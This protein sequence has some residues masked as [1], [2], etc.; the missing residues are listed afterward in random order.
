M[1]QL[2]N[3]A[4]KSSFAMVYCQ[5]FSVLA[6][7]KVKYF[8]HP[9]QLM[10]SQGVSEVKKKKK[11]PSANTGNM[12]LFPMSGRSLGKGNGN[13]PQYSCLGNPMD[14]ITWHGYSPWGL[15]GVGN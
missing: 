1:K 5:Y 9:N 2:G 3:H 12:G 4:K 8:Q 7:E 15:K 10:G 6:S 13:P 11:D 14:R